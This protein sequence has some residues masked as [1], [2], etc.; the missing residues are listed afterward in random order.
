MLGLA[1]VARRAGDLA[2]TASLLG[3]SDS[4]RAEI[5]AELSPYDAP[6]VESAWVAIREGLGEE[7]AR[8]AYEAGRSQPRDEALA[9]ASRD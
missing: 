6:K 4:I 5:G 3:S 8:E 7:G 2:R 9:Y 1:F